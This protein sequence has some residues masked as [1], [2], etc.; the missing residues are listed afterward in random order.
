MWI[1]TVRKWQNTMLEAAA[2]ML[3]RSLSGI[4]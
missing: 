2:E 4:D 3:P 1:S